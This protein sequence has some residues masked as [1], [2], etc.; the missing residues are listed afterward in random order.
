MLFC[1]FLL[2]RLRVVVQVEINK[3]DNKAHLPNHFLN[4]QLG[5]II[6]VAGLVLLG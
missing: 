4:F 2:A 5:W 3:I 1:C 6:H